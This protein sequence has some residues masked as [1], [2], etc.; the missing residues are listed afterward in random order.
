MRH[1]EIRCTNCARL[2]F[3]MEPKALAG[4]LSI[5]CP[6]CRSINILRPTQSPNLERPYNKDNE[7]DGTE[8]LCGCSSPKPTERPLRHQPLRRCRR[9]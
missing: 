3:K 5:K 7:R 6:R 1:E 4:D 2:L 9:T 8:A